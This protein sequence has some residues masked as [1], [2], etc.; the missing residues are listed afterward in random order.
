[1]I[2]RLVLYASLGALLSAF[3]MHW[4]S[5]EFWCILGLFWASSTVAQWQGR[6]EGIESILGMS[7]WKITQ[8]KAQLERIDR[9]VESDEPVDS[10]RELTELERIMKARDEDTK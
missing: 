4:D 6:R 2:T 8:I 3:D 1:M 9:A 7:L 5:V 10:D